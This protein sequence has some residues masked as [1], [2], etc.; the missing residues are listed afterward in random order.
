MSAAAAVPPTGP[1]GLPRS[2][3]LSR[4]SRSSTPDRAHFFRILRQQTS[5]GAEHPIAG[6]AEAWQ[7]IAVIIQPFV[8]R[9]RPDRNVGMFLSEV[10]DAF[11]RSQ[12][13]DE[14][15]VARAARFEQGSPGAR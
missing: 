4:R 10:R 13:A 9:G 2:T 8:D 1:N 12:Q 5:L 11:R 7:D 6:V 3:N 15:Y 14:P